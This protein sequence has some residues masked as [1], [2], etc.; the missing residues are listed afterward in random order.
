MEPA[1]TGEETTMCP[2]QTCRMDFDALLA[3]P[4]TR[5]MM[6]SDGVSEGELIAVLQMARDA[7][8]I[9]G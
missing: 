6:E 9:E 5:A 4:L 7:R 2:D 8:G 1:A 3:D